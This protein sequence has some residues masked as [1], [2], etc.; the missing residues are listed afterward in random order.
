MKK[1]LNEIMADAEARNRFGTVHPVTLVPQPR[2]QAGAPRKVIDCTWLT[3]A[4]ERRSTSDI[5]RFLG[6]S[7]TL[8]QNH[9]LEYGLAEPAEDPFV[10]TVDPLRPYTTLFSQVYSTSG[11]V[12]SWTDAQLDAAVTHL[13]VV[14]PR[15][16]IS[17]LKGSLHSLGENV[18]RERIRQSLLR[19]DPDNRLFERP[20]I[21]RRKYWVPGPNYLWH[22]DGQ[23]GQIAFFSR[24]THL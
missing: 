7:R 10:R 14:F 12:S 5:A 18:P 1:D 24:S 17:M 20:L 3:W 19:L 2:G 11:A 13:R 4:S 15:A 22:H 8:V 21:E 16:G 23:H 6:V 9:L